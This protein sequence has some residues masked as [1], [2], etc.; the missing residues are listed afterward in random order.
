MQANAQP[1]QYIFDSQQLNSANLGYTTFYIQQE[2]GSPS[3]MLTP[4]EVPS[5]E[6]LDALPGGLQIDFKYYLGYGGNGQASGSQQNKLQ[7][8]SLHCIY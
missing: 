6:F 2:D 3:N 4:T 7:Q 1:N 8:S 5:A